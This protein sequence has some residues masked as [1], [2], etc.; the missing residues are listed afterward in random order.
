MQA[1]T[2]LILEFLT[3]EFGRG[4]KYNTL[5]G[6][7][8]AIAKVTNLEQDQPIRMFRKGAYNLRPPTAKYHTIRDTNRLLAYLE[9]MET[10]TAREYLEKLLRCSCYC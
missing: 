5:R 2:S 1:D 7:L 10:K 6:S 9:T 8:T 4:L 3:S